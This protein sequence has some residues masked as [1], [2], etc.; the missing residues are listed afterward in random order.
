MSIN[1]NDNEYIFE[2]EELDDIEYLEIMS[3]DDI[4]KDNP[5]FIALSREE[6]KNSLFELFANK[7]KANNITNLFYDIIN[8]IDGN[9]GKLKNYDNYVFDAEAEKND[10]SADMADKTEVANFNNLKKKTV[11]NHDIAKEKYFFCIKYNKDSEKLRFKP[12][13]KINI[14]IEPRDKGFPIYY[15][16]FPADDVN[17]PIISAYYKIPKTVINDYLYTK[18]TS[19]LTTTKNMNMNINYVSSENCE[20]VSE[21]IK[22]VRPDISN[23]IEYLKD[24]FELDYYNIEN[25]LNKFGKSLDFINKEDFG[26]L[27]DYLTDVMEQYKER[28]NVS[29][30]VKIKKPD[31]INKKL[32]FFD[33]LNTS[34]Q[35]LN[36]TEKVID[37]LDKNKMSLEDY[38]E[39][40]IMTDKIKPLKDLKTYDIVDTIRTMGIGNSDD[41]A[42]ILEILDIIT[43]SLKNSNI[44]E[45][46]QSIDDILKTH[47]KKEII[48]KKYEIARKENEYSRNHIFDYDKD[49]KQYLISYREHKEI[50]DSHY[51]DKNEGIPMI[52]FETQE[53]TYDVGNGAGDADAED[54]GYI[55]G[56]NELSRYDI[57]KYITNIIYKNELGF[58][59]SLENMLNILNN[60][61]KS[62]NIEFD[63][64][65]LCSELFKYNRSISKRRDMYI[66]AFQDNDL[67]I[68]EEMLNYLDKL[69][70][71][72]ILA[73]I[74]N[75]DK[76]FS[77]IDDNV[78]NVIESNNKNWCE[79][80]NDMFLNALAYCIINLQD[81]ILNDTIFID[82][83]YLNG[84]FL[85]YWDNCGS[86]LNKKEDRGVMSYII[87]VAT[88]YL[89]N[90]SNNEF[91]IETDNM[92]KNTYKVI[93]KYYSENLERMKKK[94]DICREKKKEQKGKIERDK[95]RSLLKNKECGKEYS[96]CRE[97]YIQ[98]LIY[99]PDVNYVKIHK[100]LNG[101]CL[102]KL[103]DSF[104][105]DIDLKNAN[106]PELIGFK[107][108][109]AEK[110]M[111]N[112]PRDLRFIPKKTAKTADV[113]D[114][115]EIVERI[116]L[117][118]YIYDMNNNSMIVR[119]WLE[120]MKGKNNSVFPDNIIADFENGNIKS[121]KNSII[122]NV[123]LL[124]KTSKHSGDEF[125]N[126]FN[127]VRKTG[128]GGKGGKEASNDK[129]KY[130]NIIRA[131]IKT[132][133]KHLRAE[134]NNEEIKVLLTNSIKDLRDIIIDLKELNK[135]YNDDIENEIEIINK[136]IVSMA[137][138]CPFNIGN[139]LNGK[140]I[141]DIISSQYI[142][143]IT[144]SV[145][146]DVFKI[147]K[148]TFPTLDENIDFLNKQREKNKQEKIKAFNK[149]TVEENALIKEL[150][151][152]GFK[153]DLLAEKK[154]DDEEI[155]NLFDNV[156]EP[157]DNGDENNNEFNDIFNDNAG[158]AEG[159]GG[160]AKQEIND[161]NMLM[162][163][164]REDDDENMDTVDMGFLYN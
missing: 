105:E 159:A 65:A 58:V 127:N 10:Y 7:K 116:Y 2:E 115:E 70:P 120:A 68:S 129:I 59:D 148:I 40:N 91:L 78:G 15:P 25:V 55:T 118:D 85:S 155:N 34:I 23:I 90:N 97:Q 72:S 8:D 96:L 82:V 101:C 60:I 134:D 150:K 4:I 104:N 19:H 56:Y 102:K 94:D 123:S 86:P 51:N 128:K 3:L 131:I 149:I 154:E 110:K 53:A 29:R 112:K 161:E 146:D 152:A 66:K 156:I 136:Y 45:A 49:G 107:K 21:L 138:C 162:T 12:E 27:C 139:T 80:F 42:V 114:A 163:Y 141:S 13:A 106:R 140:I 132:I 143:K 69:S 11:I 35:L 62:A 145:Y 22:G 95:L 100:F 84:N 98:S 50:K 153:Q 16:V 77:D 111:T 1:I 164:D 144:A 31:I 67:E 147:I 9:R 113:D 79:E 48:V 133:Y 47:E 32:I 73:L 125:I 88:D 17:I 57:E 28:K 135:I 37:F 87:E 142:Y 18:I 36:I 63:Y 76:P 26:I 92:F 43:H 20:N 64:D 6:I 41:N 157:G 5:S 52:E 108:K 33:K 160:A 83:D 46:I 39:N 14:T 122:S 124:T 137:L 158:G 151:K 99:M 44:L 130:L 103:D 38:R 126:N 121:I 24:S 81:K 119:R 75:R 71:K 74:N 109:Y 61:G 117:D 89:I 54:I 30:P 93:E